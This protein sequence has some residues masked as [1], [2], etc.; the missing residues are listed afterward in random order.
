[1]FHSLPPV[2]HVRS[3]HGLDLKTQAELS[4]VGQVS[5]TRPK[6]DLPT[7]ESAQTI[8]MK[9]LVLERKR[10][11]LVGVRLETHMVDMFV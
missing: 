8:A 3:L 4:V 6:E 11:V 9:V 10:L 2:S 1:M 5:K 7:L